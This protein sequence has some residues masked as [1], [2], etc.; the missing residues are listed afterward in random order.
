MHLLLSALAWQMQAT[1]ALAPTWLFALRGRTRQWQG[2]KRAPGNRC[3]HFLI[4]L[5][6]L[7]LNYPATANAA[8]AAAAA[9]AVAAAVAAVPLL[10]LLLFDAPSSQ[11]VPAAH[12]KQ[13]QL[14]QVPFNCVRF[15]KEGKNTCL[16]IIYLLYI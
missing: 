9:A 5:L 7:L 4:L 14:L 15:Y 16:K 10:L 13:H 12:Q 1:P 6:L 2:P 3:S 8:V 11:Q